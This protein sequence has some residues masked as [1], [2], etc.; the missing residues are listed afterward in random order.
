MVVKKDPIAI[1]L[2]LL[3]MSCIPGAA[4]TKKGDRPR[5]ENTRSAV[6]VLWRNPTDIASR[7]LFYGPGGENHR[8]HGPYTFLK[9]DLGGTNP[10]LDVRSQDGVKWKIKLGAEARPETAASR[11]VWAVGYF[12]NEDYFVPDLQVQ[13]LPSHLHR[14]RKLIAPDGSMHKVRLKRQLEGEKKIGTWQWQQDPFTATRELNGLRVL[15]A[16]INNWD[17]KDENNAVYQEGSRRIYFVSDLGA[18][19]GTAGRNWPK[20]KDRDNLD[21]Y[22]NSKFIRK[23]TDTTVD[24]Q[25]PARPRFVFLV[26]PK[27]YFRRRHLEWIG[28]GIPRNDARWIGQLLAL[29]SPRQIRDAFRAAGYSPREVEGFARVVESR[30][31]TLT[32]L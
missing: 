22:R 17:L 5:E 30:I 11:I 2:V 9:E 8:P 16:L 10:K 20:G 3:A 26:N 21:A 4:T 12:V 32:D 1:P 25:A 14:G 18:S 13:D 28:R 15:M 19:F 27:E 7:N 29:L 23:V 6:A 31:A 24:F